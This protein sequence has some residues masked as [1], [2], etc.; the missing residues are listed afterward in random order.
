MFISLSYQE[1][2]RVN[3]SKWIWRS[4]GSVS[5]AAT[6]LLLF[7]FVAAVRS[8]M[9]PEPMVSTQP[10]NTGS[11]QTQSAPAAPTQTGEFRVAAIG[12]SLAKGT[13]DDSGSGFVRRAV[14]LLNEQEGHQARLINNLGI[15]GL[16][17]QG[18]L[19]KLDEPGVAYVLKK[20]N[21]I[22]VSIGGNDLFQ[23][24]QAAETGKEPPTLSDLRKALPDASKRLQKV[25]TK[26]GKINPK[27]KIIY[28][29]LYNPFSDLHGVKIPG[30]LIVT[31]WNLAAM[32][33]TNQNSNMTLVPTFDLFQQ[34]LP[35]YLSS[36]HFHPNGQ[37]Y[38]AIAE[39]I[40]QGF[41]VT[42]TGDPNHAD[43]KQQSTSRQPAEGKK[44]GNKS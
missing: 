10:I 44:G 3:S 30:N 32:A 29:G 13:G 7:G 26:V 19:T 37:G 22:I 1:G 2:T 27:A 23:G 36:D 6:L 14:D 40:A 33:V 42:A 35:V 18:L 4:V 5:I 39:R 8:I 43:D 15:N 17:T 21:V 28:V 9:A 34:N 24:A 31:E 11:S 38:Q 16:T 20:A 41:A 12:D 25:L